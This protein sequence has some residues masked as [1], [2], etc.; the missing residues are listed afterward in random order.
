MKI[1]MK[2]QDLEDDEHAGFSFGSCLIRLLDPRLC[3]AYPF[4]FSILLL[5]G[6][7]DGFSL[8]LLSLHLV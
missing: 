3:R 7:N 2:T 4:Q 5:D 8:H 1:I 6:T